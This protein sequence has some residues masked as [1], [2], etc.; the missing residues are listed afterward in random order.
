MKLGHLSKKTVLIS[1]L[2]T[3]LCTSIGI[4]G[5][6][7]AE[8]STQRKDNGNVETPRSATSENTDPGAQQVTG[9]GWLIKYD[10]QGSKFSIRGTTAGL[11]DQVNT[12]VEEPATPGDGETDADLGPGHIILRFADKDGAPDPSSTVRIVEYELYQH[13]QV[14]SAVTVETNLVAVM[15]DACGGALGAFDETTLSWNEGLMNGVTSK[16]AVICHGSQTLCDLGGLAE[17]ENP[18]DVTESLPLNPFEFPTLDDLSSFTMAEVQVP[19]GGTQEELSDTFLELL[20]R[21]V[22]RT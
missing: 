7:G 8:N 13:F 2:I 14:A 22:E 5:C 6:S 1:P 4:I 18:R 3:G 17:G 16:G 19:A 20:G 21:E 15:K 9:P 10:L 12:V 11:G